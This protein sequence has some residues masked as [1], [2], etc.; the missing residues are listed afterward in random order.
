MQV[1]V[2]LNEPLGADLGPFTITTDV[3]IVSPSTANRN[4]LI[5]GLIVNLDDSA[6]SITITS[7]VSTAC[8]GTSLVLSITGKPEP[9]C[10]CEFYNITVSNT[11][12]L[13]ATGN[14]GVLEAYNNVVVYRFTNCNDVLQEITAPDSGTFNNVLCV[15]DGTTI[16]ITYYKNNIELSALSSA[17]PTGIPCCN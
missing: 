3:G 6:T 9:E 1:L 8:S 13:D 4:D 2:T 10:N 5:N 12:I 16:S 11:D 15:K 7:S 14:I 17:N